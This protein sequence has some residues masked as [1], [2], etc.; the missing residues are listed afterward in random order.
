[1]EKPIDRARAGMASDSDDSTPGPTTTSAAE[2]MQLARTATGTLGAAAKTRAITHATAAAAP[3]IRKICDAPLVSARLV[4]RAPT[5]TPT[6]STS[7]TGTRAHARSMASRWKTSSYMSEAS[8]MKPMMDA[9]RNGRAMK[10]RRRL[11]MV[12]TMRMASANDGGGSSTVVSTP[13]SAASRSKCPRPGSRS[14][15]PSTTRI[16][17]GKANTTNGVRHVNHVASPAPM[18]K[19][20]IWPMLLAARWIEYTFGRDRI[21]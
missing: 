3:R 9:A 17:V 12:H 14:R 11:R 5:A 16:I 2:I 4:R 19:P 18:T 7:C 13:R 1:M 10:M 6:S 20:R 21:G 15:R 8:E